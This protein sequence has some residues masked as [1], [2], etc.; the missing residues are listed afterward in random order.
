MIGF[1]GIGRHDRLRTLLSSYI[2]GQVSHKEARRVDEHLSGCAGCRRDLETLRMSVGLLRELPDLEVPRS[3]RIESAPA[4]IRAPGNFV[5]A[6]GLA[7][8]MAAMLLVALIAGDAFGVFAQS[9]QAATGPFE[10][11]VELESAAVAPEAADE[12]TVPQ[13]AA[14]RAAEPA[15]AAAPPPETG[16]ETGAVADQQTLA[17]QAPQDEPGGAEEEVTSLLAAEG[18][19]PMPGGLETEAPAGP[20]DSDEGLELPLLQLQVAAGVLFLLLL[21]ATLWLGRRRRWSR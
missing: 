17:A 1:F 3:F 9:G 18:E 5:W 20:P 2:D 7:A 6:T 14:G 16:L 12:V 4:S 10:T 21:L 19:R 11:D 13:Q 15:T 8:S